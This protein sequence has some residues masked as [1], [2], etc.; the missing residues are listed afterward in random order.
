MSKLA[1]ANIIFE[2]TESNRIE[3]TGNNVVRVR[4]NGGMQIPFGTTAQRASPEFGL[5]RYN[6][7]LGTVETYDAS[8]WYIMP[9]GS[10]VNNIYTTANAAFNAAN[11]VSLAAAN[12]WANTKVAS[13]T[14]NSTSRIWANTVL[15]GNL[16]E[17]VF[18]DLAT[19]GVTAASYGSS[20]NIP[21]VTIDAYGRVTYAAN[22]AV[23]GMDYPYANTVGTAG[24]NYTNAVGTAG[25]NYASIL[26]ANNA[27]GANAWANT[28]GTAGNNYTNAV[29]TAGNNYT[30][31]MDTAGNNYAS[32]LV[33][34]NA[35]GAN[36]WA[37]TKLANTSGVAFAGNLFFPTGNVS[38]GYASD[39]NYKLAINGNFVANTK[40]FLIPHPTKPNMKLRYAS[41]EGPE[42]GVYLRGR[43]SGENFI[44]YPEYW[45][46]L[47]DIDTITVQLT[48][49][50]DTV[51]PRV[52]G[53]TEN[54]VLL[55]NDN[56][57][58]DC[59]YL[60]MAERKDVEKLVVEF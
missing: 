35:V 20:T 8:G 51:M 21:I 38:I 39:Q 59:Y 18:I 27:V 11:N 19:S 6:T 50:G 52:A 48:P 14:S 31:A 54:G 55:L 23:Q 57:N 17:N 37:N 40:S 32:V 41:L 45:S 12:N 13:V 4:A 26:A 58:I 36:T 29:G 33:A 15:T 47:V 5:I 56:R 1:V 46:T 16:S 25:N 60:I 49:I 30:I 42:N 9:T 7:D 53:V 24:N 34:N 44:E 2:T 43:L 3:Y 10:Y 28:V 22:V